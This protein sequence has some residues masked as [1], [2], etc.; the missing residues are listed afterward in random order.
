MPVTE[1]RRLGKGLDALLGGSVGEH[2]ASGNMAPAN[3]PL[4]QIAINPFQPRRDFDPD[5][6]ASLRESLA[7]HGLLQ[8]IVVRQTERGY[9]LIAGERRLRAAREVGWKEIP[10]RVVDF[11]DQQ[12]FEAALVENVQRSDLNPIE[13]ALGFQD[14][15]KQ[16]RVTQDELARK[17]GL[18]RSTISNL[19][20]L[21]EL[22]PEVQ[23]A[24]RVGQISNGHARA[25]LPLEDSAQQALLCKEIIAK[26]LSV[27]AVEAVVKQSQK[28][29]PQEPAETSRPTQKTAHVQAI[30]DELRQKLATKLEI[31]VRGQE[32]G[33]IVLDF[34]TNDDFERI[35]EILRK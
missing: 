12:V 29:D 8:P 6:L 17:I 3:V 32:K 30:E 14:Y 11:N 24:V 2:D 18:D 1:R 33:Q 20:R 25:L 34:E 19:I 10:V 27:R 35:V 21:L 13:K 16:Y 15:L 9:Q 31:R 7:T 4:D 28:S 23:D 26:G 22:P 5:E